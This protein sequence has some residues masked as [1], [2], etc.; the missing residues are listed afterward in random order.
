[1]TTAE[2]ALDTSDVDKHIGEEVGGGQ[3]KEPIA[4]IDVRR[5]VQAMNYP[6]ARH[7]DEEAAARSPFGEIVAPQSFTVCCDVGHGAV[8]AVVGRIPNSHVIFGGDEFWF[9]GPHIRPGDL[10]RVRRRFDGYSIAETKFA[11]P[12]MFSRG[13]TT[14]LNQ[15]KEAIAKQ[16]STMVRYLPEL[17][18]KRGYYDR[19]AADAPTWTD[20]QLQEL[21]RQ[22]VEWARSGMGGEGPSQVEVGDMLPV[23]P[24][25]PH[26]SAQFVTEY[27]TFM[28]T[29]WGSHYIEGHYYGNDAGFLPD[30]LGAEGDGSDPSMTIGLDRG[31][32]SGHTNVGKAKLVG[33]PRAYGYG[34]SIGAWVLDYVAYWAGDSGFIR[35]AKVDYRYPTFEGDLAIVHGVV[36]EHRWEPALGVHLAKVGITMTNQ[37]DVLLAKAFVDVQLPPA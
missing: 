5:W 35:H 34:S 17:A 31:P 24:I 10:V 21:E 32:A 9:Y 30:L 15:R 20:A 33:L 19:D 28:F 18:R 1:M 27:R 23:R 3:L 26:T 14:Y 8:P 12:T 4:L 13:D 7:F 16:R 22:Q 36:Q 37:D 29:V 2:E 25:G 11:G 6:N